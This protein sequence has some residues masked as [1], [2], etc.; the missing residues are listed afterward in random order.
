MLNFVG[1]FFAFILEPVQWSVE[2]GGEVCAGDQLDASLGWT[3]GRWQQKQPRTGQPLD[4]ESKGQIMSREN[5][6]SS[7]PLKE[8]PVPVAKN[9]LVLEGHFLNSEGSSL[10]KSLA[11]ICIRNELGKQRECP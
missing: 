10:V 11:I 6:K 7:G 8:R 1:S 2:A 9:S 5:S 3:S 4:K